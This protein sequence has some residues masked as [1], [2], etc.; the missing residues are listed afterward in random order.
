L[1]AEKTAPE[2]DDC[3]LAENFTR[4]GDYELLERIARGG[5][6]VVYRARQTSLGREVAVKVLLDSLIAGPGELGRFRAE[7]TAAAALHHPNI[8]SIHEVGE[9]DGQHFFSMDF[10]A[11]KDLAAATS[12]G[13]LPA[14]EAARLT[15][16]IAEAVQHAHDRGILHRDLKPSNVLVDAQGEPRVTDFGLAKRMDSTTSLKTASE[17]PGAKTAPL[18]ITGQVF[19]TPGYMSPEQA[20]AKRDIGPATDVY[21]LG[22]LLY[23]LLTGRAPFVGESPAVVLRQVAENEPVPASLLNPLVPRDL[24]TI[25]LKCLHK[26]PSHR[27]DSAALMAADLGRFLR[28]EPILA[29]PVSGLE[30]LAR[31]SRRNPVIASL[32][33]AVALLLV[34]LAAGSIL[35]ARRQEKARQAEA[36]LRIEGEERLRQSEGLINFMLG[37]LADRLEP[38]GRLDVLESTINQVDQFYARLTPALLTAESQ[39]H[40][41]K[42]LF[43]FADIR[44]AQGRLPES[45]TNYHAAIQVYASL[46]AEHPTNLQW[47]FEQTR[48]WN[49]LG[50]AYA[51]QGDFTNAAE[52]LTRSLKDRE[53]LI[54]LQPTNVFWLASYGSTAQNL[55]QV[56]RHLGNLQK[57]GDLLASAEGAYRSWVQAEPHS[58]TPKERLATVRGSAGQLLEARGSLDE[59]GK[60]YAGKVQVLRELLRAEPQHTRRQAELATGLNLSGALQLKQSNFVAAVATLSEGI[61]IDESLVAGDPANREWQSDLVAQLTA[62]GIALGELKQDDQALADYRRVWELSEAQSEAARQNQEWM[63]NWRQ[64]LESGQELERAQAAQ[65]LAHGQAGKAAEHKRLTDDLQAKLQ[66]LP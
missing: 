21:S 40:R 42:A 11:G 57:A 13:P 27:Y 24:D 59:A 35:S 63:K 60:A 1:F 53:A 34:L 48:T 6:G 45:I 47:Q 16:K 30:R 10:V 55:G 17:G 64:S 65:A 52:A 39:G 32:T 50:I 51:R 37:D 46:L 18:T 22:A 49:D 26:A 33:T 25:C 8:V 58:L 23:H 43:Q 41:A 36:N 9:E 3:G 2:P 29:R 5:M 38:V 12:G 7:A 31:W 62:R 4:I 44:A 14:A 15:L 56:E 66:K 19:G 20:A 61:K 54:R 28:Q